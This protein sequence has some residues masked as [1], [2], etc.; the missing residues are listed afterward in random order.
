MGDTIYPVLLNVNSTE[1]TNTIQV[2]ASVYN[3]FGNVTEVYIAAFG[4]GNVENL[5]SSNAALKPFITTNLPNLIQGDPLVIYDQRVV[6][7]TVEV[8]YDAL[9]ATANVAIDTD[10]TAYDICVLAVGHKQSD[11]TLTHAF[12]FYKNN[13]GSHPTTV[14]SLPRFI[15]GN[16]EINNAFVDT[17]TPIRGKRRR[18]GESIVDKQHCRPSLTLSLCDQ[19][20]NGRQK[21]LMRMIQAI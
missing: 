9:R 18:K 8:A 12:T 10:T 6:E 21:T 17:N 16:V 14:S 3:G 4:A 5:T 2:R 7:T 15:T 20:T 1:Y 19:K 11:G 13:S